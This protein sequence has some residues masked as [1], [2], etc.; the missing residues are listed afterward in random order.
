MLAVTGEAFPL[1]VVS[2]DIYSGEVFDEGFSPITAWPRDRCNYL[3]G[4]LCFFSDFLSMHDG[5]SHVVLDEYF[6]WNFGL[7]QA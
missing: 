5:Q 7:G 3:L 4:K 1:C 2:R 6:S